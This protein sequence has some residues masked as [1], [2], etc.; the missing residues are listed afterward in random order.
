MLQQSLERARAGQQQAEEDLLEL[1]SIPSVS[2]LP[3][4]R[5]DVRRAGAWIADR[6][7]ACGM[8]VEVVEGLGNPVISAEW[9]ERPGRPTLAIYGHYD[10]QPADPIS[11]WRTPPFEPSRRDGMVFARGATDDKGQLMAGINA[12]VHALAEGGPEINLRFLIEGEEEITGKALPG[13]VSQNAERL[14]SD[15]L[16]IADGLF[17]APGK[18]NLCTALR[19]LVGGEIVVK[20][21][22]ADLHSGIY[23][24]VAPNPMNSLAQII[25]ALKGRDGRVT[26][27]GFYDDVRAPD[28]AELEAWSHV[29]IDADSLKRD[30]RVPELEGE[31]DRSP[32]ERMW[33][34]P[35]LDVHGIVGG[36]TGEGMKTVIPAVARAKVTMRLVPDQHPR[37]I[38][39]AVAAYVPTLATAGVTAEFHGFEGAHPVRCGTDHPGVEAASDAFEAAFGA[40]PLLVREGGSIPVVSD[41]QRA[42]SPRL[43]VTGFGLPGDGLHSPN[44]HFSLDQFHRGTEMVLHLM[45]N[46]SAHSRA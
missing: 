21:A 44:E 36:F 27:P 41:F 5:D 34:R 1:L 22:A 31:A 43:L 13:F 45:H 15:Y 2:A 17:T 10:V 37:R 18:P 26:V 39:E 7:K 12:A 24:G 6:L 8:R 32:L 9:L 35:T 40:R 3:E 46:L 25:A 38:A 42:L 20:G 19:G 4:H 30:L 23:G 28:A 16:F 33:A 14:R 29:P 11:E